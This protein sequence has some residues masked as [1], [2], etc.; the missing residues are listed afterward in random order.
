MSEA[1]THIEPTSWEMV[2]IKKGSLD[3]KVQVYM[4]NTYLKAT[5]FMKLMLILDVVILQKIR[6]DL[7]T[8]NACIRKSVTG[9]VALKN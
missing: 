1:K 7:Q 4:K 3:T 8:C 6:S 9:R 2:Q 5:N